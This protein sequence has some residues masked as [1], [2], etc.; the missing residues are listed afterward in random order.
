MGKKLALTM[1]VAGLI[2]TLGGGAL[3][4]AWN[5]TGLETPI[6]DAGGSYVEEGRG[7][8]Y[9]IGG[10]LVSVV[11]EVKG[12]RLLVVDSDDEIVAIWSNTPSLD[13]D[14]IVRVGSRDGPE[15]PMTEDILHQYQELKGGID[16]TERGLVFP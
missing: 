9:A 3:A 15:H 5:E 2:L 14:L 12:K 13:H 1:V 11:G 7:A 10:S 4:D 8:D 16:W 6:R